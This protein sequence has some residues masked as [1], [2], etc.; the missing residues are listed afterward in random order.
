MDPRAANIEG[1]NGLNELFFDFIPFPTI[2]Q[3]AKADITFGFA[4]NEKL[5]PITGLDDVTY[6]GI[7]LTGTICPPLGCASVSVP[8]P[9]AGAGLPGLILVG[10][11]VLGWWRRRRKAT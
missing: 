3:F 2:F 11:G 5:D 9:I 10:G 1:P 4:R 7:A 6:Y 8:G